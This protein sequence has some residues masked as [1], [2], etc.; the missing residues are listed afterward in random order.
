MHDVM[1]WFKGDDLGSTVSPFEEL[2][3]VGVIP[4]KE[5]VTRVEFDF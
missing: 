5:R 1:M 3:P 2:P 4:K